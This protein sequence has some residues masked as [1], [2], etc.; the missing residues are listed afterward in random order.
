MNL[1]NKYVTKV[2][3]TVFIF[4]K[5]NFNF[6]K[7]HSLFI[8][9]SFF[10]LSGCVQDYQLPMDRFLH[11][12]AHKNTLCFAPPS[13]R[14]PSKFAWLWLI[15]K[16][17]W[18]EGHMECGYEVLMAYK[19]SL[20][21]T[22]K[23]LVLSW[24]C[25]NPPA[26]ADRVKESAVANGTRIAARSVCRAWLHQTGTVTHWARPGSAHLSSGLLKH[27]WAVFFTLE[28]AINQNL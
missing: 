14:I 7:I 10:F 13:R 6:W 26:L 27:T 22:Y 18:G 28:K 11:I 25:G 23:Y 20:C 17:M 8:L 1:T 19:Y 12:I 24:A 21:F 2:W 9:I 3:Y 5:L 4:N 15:E 16:H